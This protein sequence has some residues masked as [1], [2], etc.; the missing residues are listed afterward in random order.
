MSAYQGQVGQF[1]IV[2]QN[3][4][5]KSVLN[6]DDITL[7]AGLAPIPAIPTA[8]VT[9]NTTTADVAWNIRYGADNWDLRYRPFVDTSGNPIEYNFNGAN[10][11]QHMSGWMMHDADGDGYSWGTDNIEGTLDFY[12]YSEL[13]ISDT[14]GEISPD[15]YLFSPETE[16]QGILRFTY[17]GVADDEGCTF[18]DRLMVYAEIGDKMKPLVAEDYLVTPGSHQTVTID[19]SQF[20][21][22]MGRIVFRHYNSVN[23]RTVFLD[24]IFIGDPD[25]VLVL[26]EW[27]DVKGLAEPKYTIEGL[28]LDTKY[29][30]QVMAYNEVKQ[31]DW[32][33]VVTFTTLGPERGDV[34]CDGK[35]SVSDVAALV[36]IIL[37][38]DDVEP[39]LYNHF[40]ADTNRDKNISI[41][42][43]TTLVKYI[44][45]DKWP[46]MVYT[47]V[48]PEGIFGSDWDATN[49][50]N[51][52]VKGADGAYTWTK[53]GV[54]LGGDFEFK[55][56]G[57][58][59]NRYYEW[60]IDNKY[61]AKIDG[62]GTYDI[63]IKFNP[64]ADDANRITCNLTKLHVYTVVG[65]PLSVFGPVDPTLVKG[66]NGIYT[67]HNEG[68]YLTEGTDIYFQ[69]VQDNDMNIA[70]PAEST[71]PLEPSKKG[72]WF[73][74]YETG[75]WGFVI[76]FNPGNGEVTF[77][78]TKYF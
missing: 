56:V 15:N 45:N 23:Q 32:S 29:E 75:V 55:V 61:V 59:D 21:G 51:N 24:D 67:W 13:G 42:D 63:V 18:V 38:Y 19:L 65:E 52:M 74:L 5:G 40:V 2:H 17:W 62:E 11:I 30:V 3:T 37:G 22:Q 28:T 64:E 33:D 20:G 57:D 60:P 54:T 47:V 73:L 27:T 46:E 34:N 14:T 44:L 25:D 69:V 39:Y 9:P 1:A 68:I 71:N 10:Y 76:T 66:E 72:W 8:T 48:G 26:A 12:M 70:W 41:T 31:S 35:V 36:N 7:D 16:L 58:H 4:T 78:P 50:A 6:I 77:V 43:I 53:N 49:N